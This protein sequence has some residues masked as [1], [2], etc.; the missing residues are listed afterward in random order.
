LGIDRATISSLPFG[1]GAAIFL[2]QVALGTILFA[3]FQE[4][5][6]NELGAGDAWAG[7]LLGA[8]GAARFV[9]ETPTGAVSDRIER[10]LG[11]LVGFASMLPA[12]VLMGI[13]QEYQAY[14]LFAAMLGVGTAFLWP[15]AYA[16][17][18]DLYQETSRGKVIGFLNLC[19][20]LGFGAGALGGALVVESFPNVMFF[21]AGIAIGV[22]W[23]VVLAYIPSYRGGRLWGWLPPVQRPS[24]WSILSVRLVFLSALILATTTALAM[25]VPAIRPY[26]EDVLGRSFAT[27]T[28]ALTP[29]LILGSLFFIPAGHMA[30]K[31][32]RPAPFIL[33][34]FLVVL[35]LLTVAATVSLP[36]AAMGAFLIFVG[37]V[38]SVPAWNAEIMDLAPEVYRGTLIGLTVALTGLGLAIGP[39][40]G[41]T[42]TAEYGAPTT[43]RVVAAIC[44]FVGLAVTLY[45]WVYRSRATEPSFDRPGA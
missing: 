45:A 11:L 39:A 2:V 42:L 35:G 41:G 32:G 6:P 10:K 17:S 8:Y 18:A 30:D 3:T 28:L 21:V 1:L 13:Y 22:A 14:L 27:L 24:I 19:Q 23:V 26:G 29:A 4:F 15:A 31:L 43:F 37:N 5:V 25:V 9:F 12:V 38:F 20:L 16:I 34:Q 40:V 7:Y 44:A 33:G 36:V